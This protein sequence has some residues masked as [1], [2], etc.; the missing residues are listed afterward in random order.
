MPTADRSMYEDIIEA[1]NTTNSI[2]QHAIFERTNDTQIIIPSDYMSYTIAKAMPKF[3]KPLIAVMGVSGVVDLSL[4]A[5]SMLPV[6]RS[7]CLANAV[8]PV[9]ILL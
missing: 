9:V 8:H 1:N 6:K 3:A 4:Q 5:C 2:C 7:R